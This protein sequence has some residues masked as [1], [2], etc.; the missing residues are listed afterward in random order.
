MAFNIID[1]VASA[2]GA[3]NG[4]GLFGGAAKSSPVARKDDVRLNVMG[5]P[6]TGVDLVLEGGGMRGM[7]TAGVL[8]VLQEHGV[9]GFDTVWGVSAGAI[10]AAS[11][12]SR[13]IGRYM[14]ESLAFRDDRRFMSLWS[15][16]TTGNIAGADFM[17]H[18][19]QDDIDPFDYETFAKRRSRYMVVATDVVFGTPDYLEVRSLPE[20]IDKVLASASLPVLSRIVE[21]GERRLLDGG[22]ADSVPVERALAEGADKALAVLTQH[23]EYVKGGANELQPLADRRYSDFPYYLNALRTRAERYNA[24]REHIWELEREG[25]VVVIAPS[26]PVTVGS[27][28]GSDGEGL[29]RLYLEGRRQATETLDAVRSLGA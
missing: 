11:Y 18:A 14:R 24:Q 19:I 20:D 3:G 25:R 8:D 7:F 17:Y 16:A 22:T 4:G 2:T 9:Y 29:L 1:K 6:R 21:V 27:T 23:R 15:L 12:L 26:E 28:S 5:A 13:Q 10:N